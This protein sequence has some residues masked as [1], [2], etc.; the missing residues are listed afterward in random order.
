VTTIKYLITAYGEQAHLRRLCTTLQHIDASCSITVQYDQSKDPL[1]RTSLPA[2]VTVI[3]TPGPITWGDRS[4]LDALLIS[5]ERCLD[6]EWTWLALLSGQDY[7]IRSPAELVAHLAATGAAGILGS[8]IVPRPRDRS[9]WTEEQRRYWFRHTWIPDR[10][11]RAGGGPRGIGRLCRAVVALPGVRNRS[12]YR[13]RSRGASGGIGIRATHPPFDEARPCR[14]GMDYFLLS[15]ALACEVLQAARDDRALIDHYRH[16]A[17]PS[18]SWFHTVLGP[19]HAQDLLAEPLTFSR[20][21]GSPNPR[22]L[23]EDDLADAIAAKRFFARKF[24]RGSGRLLDR[25]DR[26]LLGI[27]GAV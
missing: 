12:Y 11:W 19:E 2:N 7:P 9:T 6:D 13:A 14:K 8:Q 15:R 22:V 23:S 18:E 1:D 26:E 3:D 24:D 17:I 16:T 25:I 5:L 4:Y 20:F 10:L 27:S 21:S